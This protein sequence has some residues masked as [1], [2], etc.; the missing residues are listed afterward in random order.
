M[1][2]GSLP[3]SCASGAALLLAAAVSA[4]NLADR[5]TSATTADGAYI[6]WREHLVDDEALGGVALRG[7]DG[8]ATAD[9]D[10][11]GHLD[12]VAV[13]ESDDQY[14]GKPEGHVRIAIGSADPDRWTLVT[15]AEGAEAGAAEDVAIGDVNGDG[16]PDIVVACELAHLIY[17]ENPGKAARTAHWQRLIPTV[18]RDRGSFIRVFLTD[19]DGDGRPEI[20]TPNKGAQDPTRA[21][22][23][24]KE[25]SFFELRG[26][27]LDDASWTEH[28]LTRVP[29]PINSQPV[30]LDGDGDLDVVAGSVAQRRMFWFEN[31]SSAQ[32]FA[33]TEHR[34]E[35]APAEPSAELLS[36]HG[37][38]VELVD[39][40][41]DGRLDIVTL[42]GGGL[43]GPELVWLEQPAQRAAAWRYRTMGSTAP[44]NLVGIVASDV[45]GD[46]DTD[47]FTGGYSGG[48]RTSDEAPPAAALGRLAWF[49]ND[50][51]RTFVRH[52]V[53]R[54][55]RG[56]FDKFVARDMDGDGDVDLLGTRGNS[57]PYDGVFWLEQVRSREPRPAFTQARERESPEIPL[58]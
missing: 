17:F 27:P 52:D 42:A 23:E 11:D 38:N 41:G 50:G 26:P 2:L 37:F 46:G 21:R 13:Y 4:Q 5:P 51:E 56:M 57:G 16:L 32:R 31:S 55:Q 6:S 7:G 39:L 15:L 9:L 48:S 25:I 14:D 30:D 10:G 19:F 54:R 24:E 45:D 43:L 12:V 49:E 3:R 1:I 33:F 28:V 20:V 58:P 22:Q 8:L 35:L 47:V 40:S 44:D 36:V 53:S 29:W 34:I 18:A